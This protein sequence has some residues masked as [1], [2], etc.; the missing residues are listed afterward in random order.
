MMGKLWKQKTHVSLDDPIKYKWSLQYYTLKEILTFFKLP[1]IVQCE[2][3]SCSI[4]MGNF[5]FD[6]QQPLLLYSKR[7]T[8]KGEARCLQKLPNGSYEETKLTVVIPEHYDGWFR[9]SR[10]MD[11]EKP[12]PHH[13]IESL[14]HSGSDFFLCTEEFSAI[15]IESTAEDDSTVERVVAAGEV[16]RKIG[17]HTINN[18][19]LPP[20]QRHDDV[21]TK[22][23][24]CIDDNDD[25]LLVPL[26]QAGVFY[27]VSDGNFDRKNCLIQIGY[28]IEE[29]EEFPV[30]LR[31]VLGEP[32]L[33]TQNY[34]PYLKLVRIIE[35]ETLMAST[36]KMDGLYPLEIQINSPIRFQIALNTGNII[37]SSEY[38]KAMELCESIDETY[39]KDI[40]F[41][42]T[43]SPP[44]VEDN[45][46]SNPSFTDDEQSELAS[47]RSSQQTTASNGTNVFEIESG[48]DLVDID[49]N[50]E[51]SI[52]WNPRRTNSNVIH[53]RKL[54]ESE[55]NGMLSDSFERDEDNAI[56]C[57]FVSGDNDTSHDSGIH[58]QAVSIGLSEDDRC[59][60]EKHLQ[61]R[62]K[63]L[64]KDLQ[65]TSFNHC[66][67][68]ADGI[69]S[70]SPSLSRT[71]TQGAS[72]SNVLP[73]M[74]RIILGTHTLDIPR[75]NRKIVRGNDFGPSGNAHFFDSIPVCNMG[76]QT[77][78]YVF[79]RT[80]A[81]DAKSSSTV[82]EDTITLMASEKMT[83][84]NDFGLP[85]S[86]RTSSSSA[87]TSD[88]ASE[89]TVRVREESNI[90]G[91]S[92]SSLSAWSSEHISLNGRQNVSGISG[93]DIET[94]VPDLQNQLQDCNLVRTT[95]LPV[96]SVSQ[97]K[98]SLTSTRKSSSWE[99]LVKMGKGGV[100]CK[101]KASVLE[102]TNMY[103]GFDD[104]YL[105]SGVESDDTND[106]NS[107]KKENKSEE[108]KASPSIAFKNVVKADI[109]E[110]KSEQTGSQN[111]LPAIKL[112]GYIPCQ[113]DNIKNNILED[114]IGSNSQ[115]SPT[116]P[117][118]SVDGIETMNLSYESDTCTNSIHSSTESLISNRSK[119]SILLSG[120]MPKTLCQT[121]RRKNE[122]KTMGVVK[123]KGVWNESSD[124]V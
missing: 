102:C 63:I 33:L 106:C 91:S 88:N 61:R 78:Y 55:N 99:G 56:E 79:N 29:I 96:F 68:S 14:I 67:G 90:W 114:S 6:L 123:V 9:I 109:H 45:A 17:V 71:S 37:S 16:L 24:M 58:S 66:F 103:G 86:T 112:D 54:P 10:Q 118:K 21:N 124:F 121:V 115:V 85:K 12:A 113:A 25:E 34:S 11:F 73:Q 27:E 1:I 72:S 30:Y 46:Y 77:E 65:K 108:D 110:I 3:K 7:F 28:M 2:E 117:V 43:M 5:F 104:L 38:L 31:H 40:K 119:R 13:S 84:I 97:R 83:K 51:F 95:S 107:E 18:M 116:K 69:L 19:M 53:N 47:N 23:L 39:V 50:S 100:T 101:N 41:A 44:I 35:E 59:F 32:P 42:F 92:R 81:G 105:I 70:R 76:Q 89:D 74:S 98:Q 36:L 57:S 60:C 62:E 75:E 49:A 94:F 80:I 64:S 8:R 20:S 4:A 22:F 111:M 122:I 93:F 48:E 82:S 87:N 52:D 120:K 26:N 15:C